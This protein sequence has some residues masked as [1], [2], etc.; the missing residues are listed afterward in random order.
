MDPFPETSRPENHEAPPVQYLRLAM[1]SKPISA[2]IMLTIVE[3]PNLVSI[4]S[5]V[6]SEFP[7]PT[8]IKEQITTR[9]HFGDAAPMTVVRFFLKKSPLVGP[10]F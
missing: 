2:Q 9:N 5:G 3:I 7:P 8:Y 10:L 1:P 6:D 4:K